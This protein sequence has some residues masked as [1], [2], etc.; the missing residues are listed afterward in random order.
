MWK[1]VSPQKPGYWL[2]SDVYIISKS[3]PYLQ[4]IPIH[5]DWENKW[6]H[7]VFFSMTTLGFSGKF[8]N[9]WNIAAN[10]I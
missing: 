2:C 7:D 1:L 9:F 3:K 8:E 10:Q 5:L 6:L 4:K